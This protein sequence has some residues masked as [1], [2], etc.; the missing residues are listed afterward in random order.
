[1]KSW[2]LIALITPALCPARPA[3]DF[4][5]PPANEAALQRGC[6]LFTAK[7]GKCHDADGRKKL[8]D[9]ST[10]LTRLAGS[11]DWQA[12]LGTR[13]KNMPPQDRQAVTAYVE[14]LLRPASQ[15]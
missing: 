15:N 9:G 11:K 6:E 12:L 13:L 8:A 7:C 5:S 3:S 4:S 14:G 1:M 10:L 2:L